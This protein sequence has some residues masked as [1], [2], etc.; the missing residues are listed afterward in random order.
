MPAAIANR[1]EIAQTIVR[2]IAGGEFLKDI[3]AESGMPDRVTFWEWTVADPELA[4]QCAHARALAASENEREVAE[5][6][7]K[8]A[9]GKIEP[10]AARVAINAH[11]WLA[12]V[13]NPKVYGDRVELEHKGRIEV[14]PVLNINLAGS[15]PPA[16]DVSPMKGGDHHG[17]K[18]IEGEGR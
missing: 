18:E 13:R 11:T 10:D 9:E 8:A 14:V 2:R 17:G 15:T 16:I 6:A 3:C 5:L 4:T 7:R 12:K 1:A